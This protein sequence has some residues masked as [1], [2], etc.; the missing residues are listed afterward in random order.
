MTRKEYST[1]PAAN[2]VRAFLDG[3]EQ[4]IR[5]KIGGTER[6]FCSYFKRQQAK[7]G[8]RW[9]FDFTPDAIEIEKL[10]GYL[11]LLR[12]N[13]PFWM[14]GPWVLKRSGTACDPTKSQDYL[15]D[16]QKPGERICTELPNSGDDQPKNFGEEFAVLLQKYWMLAFGFQDGKTSVLG[17]ARLI[18]EAN[19]ID[20]LT[21]G[22]L[23][24][25]E[26]KGT[27][28]GIAEELKHAVDEVNRSQAP[29]RRQRAETVRQRI[30]DLEKPRRK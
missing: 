19:R 29:T 12:S 20:N 7:E 3:R 5:R 1:T 26:S 21:V 15:F 4:A 30:R 10:V 23:I 16:P 11:F 9:P 8:K 28:K 22:L 13:T 2:L 24:R 6:R 14:R 17:I 27:V 18:F 25:G